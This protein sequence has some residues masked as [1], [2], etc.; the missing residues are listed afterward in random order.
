[1]VSTLVYT[2]LF[3]AFGVKV[4]CTFKLHFVDHLYSTLFVLV[5]EVDRGVEIKPK[6]K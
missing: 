5:S 3:L 2:S 6:T 1:M 4:L